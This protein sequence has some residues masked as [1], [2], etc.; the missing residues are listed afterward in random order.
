MIHPAWLLAVVA[1]EAIVIL[2]A[3]AFGFKAG[4][5]AYKGDKPPAVDLSSIVPQ[6]DEWASA[7]G[8]ISPYLE[9]KKRRRVAVEEEGE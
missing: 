5:A 2:Y 4:Y 7:P 6:K 3:V 1:I 8:P 9:R